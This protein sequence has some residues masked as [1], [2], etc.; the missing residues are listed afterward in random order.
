ML[1]SLLL[2][3]RRLPSAVWSQD[4]LLCA[5]VYNL[6]YSLTLILNQPLWRLGSQQTIQ[7]GHTHSAYNRNLIQNQ[8]LLV[9]GWHHW[10]NGHEFEQTQGDG[11]GQV[12]LVCCSPRDQKE[13]DMI[14]QRNN[15]NNSKDR[16]T[17]RPKWSKRSEM[18][19]AT[20][21]VLCA[22]GHTLAQ[23]HICGF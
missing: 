13:L 16:V 19:R 1:R 10:L 18:A 23:A 22:T 15:N 7:G 5:C 3:C 11:G 8:T 21:Q 12:N 2:A 4:H 9:V 14:E 6:N 20:P 17:M